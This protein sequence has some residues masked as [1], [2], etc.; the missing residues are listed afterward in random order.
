MASRNSSCVNSNNSIINDSICELPQHLPANGGNEGKVKKQRV[1]ELDS[2]VF[3]TSI[4][5]N[6]VQ[7]TTV[8]NTTVFIPSTGFYLNPLDGSNLNKQPKE[9][10]CTVN[11]LCWD[12]NCKLTIFNYPLPMS[13]CLP[14]Y[15]K[16]NNW[17]NSVVEA[18]NASIY[19]K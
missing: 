2:F 4:I 16:R 15:D 17:V 6:D 14:N 12:C 13:N 11:E 1:C 5:D 10:C 3:D 9:L 18:S 8:Q 7:N 19:P